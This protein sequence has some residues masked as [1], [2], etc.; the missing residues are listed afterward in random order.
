MD[1]TVK[2]ET[3]GATAL[4][5]ICMAQRTRADDH[6]RATE[7]KFYL[8][9]GASPSFVASRVEAIWAALFNHGIETSS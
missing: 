6:V 1:Y 7:S 5:L 4:L 3:D 2:P 9:A 8:P